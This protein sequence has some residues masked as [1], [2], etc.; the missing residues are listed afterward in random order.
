MMFEYGDVVKVYHAESDRLSWYKT[1]ELIGK[2]DAKNLK[3]FPSRLL[4]MA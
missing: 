2:G 3:R 4:K 1:G